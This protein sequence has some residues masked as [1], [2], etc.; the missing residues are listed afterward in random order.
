MTGKPSLPEQGEKMTFQEITRIMLSNMDFF[1]LRNTAK[2][3]DIAFRGVRRQKLMRD[4]ERTI[5]AKSMKP[6]TLAAQASQGAVSARP[7]LKQNRKSSPKGPRIGI[8]TI[9]ARNSSL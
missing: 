9:S 6:E 1:Q 8:N 4:I 3:Y 2:K 7:V 5:V